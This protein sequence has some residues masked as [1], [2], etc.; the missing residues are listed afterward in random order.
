RRP[1]DRHRRVVGRRKGHGK[2]EGRLTGVAFAAAHGGGDRDARLVVHDRPHALAV[3]DGRVGGAAQVDEERFVVFAD[4]VAVHQDGDNLAGLAGGESQ[5][6]DGA[7]V[8]AAGG[9]GGV[10]GPVGDGNRLG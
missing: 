2:S 8:V 7:L 5:G 6:G 4:P 3:G 1:V 9:G 10:S